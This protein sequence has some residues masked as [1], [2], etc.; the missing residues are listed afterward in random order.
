MKYI[1]ES[2]Y[3]IGIELFRIIFWY[4]TTHTLEIIFL[5]TSIIVITSIWMSNQYSYFNKPL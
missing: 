2:L 4:L 1:V 5:S 3:S